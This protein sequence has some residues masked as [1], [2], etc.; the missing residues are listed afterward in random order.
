MTV[1]SILS[2]C[3]NLD[4]RE[5]RTVA[6]DYLEL[7]FPTKETKHWKKMFTDILD[8]AIKPEGKQPSD[9]QLT[10]T[11]A[12]GGIYPDQTLFRKEFDDTTIIAM[13][14]PWQDDEHTTLKV[15]IFKK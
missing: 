7:V 4:I 1:E 13:F 8:S 10:M 9:E 6:D 3:S 14:W 12:Y 2:K 15:A 5:K 11:K